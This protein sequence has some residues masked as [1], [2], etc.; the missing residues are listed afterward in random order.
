MQDDQTDNAASPPAEEGK[1]QPDQQGGEPE[2]G[3]LSEDVPKDEADAGPPDG[4]TDATPVFEQAVEETPKEQ[5]LR[6]PN[7][8]KIV[9]QVACQAE[10]G[11]RRRVNSPVKSQDDHQARGQED[12]SAAQ[13]QS[14]A[15]PVEAQLAAA[16][17]P[18]TDEERAN[19]DVNVDNDLKNVV[20]DPFQVRPHP[21]I[22]GNR[23]QAHHAYFDQPGKIGR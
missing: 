10:P 15:V 4:P 16:I 12:Q 11:K 14:D 3:S 17:T 9:E 22:G 7:Q 2:Q 19:Q 20:L 1:K 8:A 21:Q 5:L 18:Q 13:A 23:R 6:Q